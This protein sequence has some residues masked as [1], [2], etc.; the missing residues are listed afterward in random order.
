MCSKVPAQASLPE[1]NQNKPHKRSER[2]PFSE[3][4]VEVE[5]GLE[6]RRK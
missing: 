4:G 6:S 2:V 3:E 1:K 5:N